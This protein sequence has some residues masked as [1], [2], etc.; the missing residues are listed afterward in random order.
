MIPATCTVLR[1]IP[2]S[3]N[4][5]IDRKALPPPDNMII[6]AEIAKA[7]AEPRTPVEAEIASIFAAVLGLRKVGIHDNFFEI[8]G[9]SLLAVQVFSRISEVFPNATP[10]LATLLQRPTAAQLAA[11]IGRDGVLVDILIKLRD[12]APDRLP[13]FCVPGAGG[14]V[15]S[16]RPL[17]MAFP[18]DLP[19]YCLQARGL[20]GSE[21][22]HSVEKTAECYVREIRAVQPTGPYF[23]GGGCYGGLVAFEMAR[24]LQQQGEQV[25]LVALMDTTNYAAGRLL[26]KHR[27]LYDHARFISSRIA[28]HAAQLKAMRGPDARGHLAN[29]VRLVSRRIR[30]L[31]AETVGL[32][33]NSFPDFVPPDELGDSQSSELIT[34]LNRVRNASIEAA[35]KFVPQPY[36]GRLIVFRASCTVDEIHHDETLGWQRMAREGVECFTIT[37]DHNSM[38]REPQVRELAE[39]LA[40]KIKAEQVEQ[41]GNTRHQ[42]AKRIVSGLLVDA[43]NA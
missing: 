42:T 18:P 29:G 19:F 11:A 27:F 30:N 8:G 36:C 15:L 16:M 33:P 7:H 9:H 25:A 28:D 1:N 10:L 14:N 32:R 24:Q 34:I 37:G 20:D 41:P 2:I 6:E 17:A 43:N 5:K 26:P 23:L 22:F 39:I 38:F 12:G 40:A 4:G 3:P 21:P 13:F 35:R 31:L